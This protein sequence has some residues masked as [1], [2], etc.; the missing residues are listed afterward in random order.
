[1]L[2]FGVEGEEASIFHSASLVEVEAVDLKNY[3]TDYDLCKIN[4]EGGEYLLLNDL[5][6]NNMITKLNNIQ[7][8]F[9]LIENYQEEY[10]KL[11]EKLS[12]T[13]ELT[14]RFPFVWENWRIK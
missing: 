12:K 5:I 6:D 10:N 8:Q 9:H 1:M 3:L 11:A 13:H 2:K 4:I 7:V 14:W